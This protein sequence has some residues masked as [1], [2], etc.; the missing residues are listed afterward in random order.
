MNQLEPQPEYI[1]KYP[2][3]DPNKPKAKRINYALAGTLLASGME[4]DQIAP[5]VGA[6]N[7]ET[8]RAG[9]A[10]KGVT[11][12]MVRNLETK[13][14]TRISVTAKLATEA[15]SIIRQRLNSG[16]IQAADALLSKS[17]TRK[18]LS[19]KGQG[20]ASTLETLSRTWRN[21]NGSPDQVQVS[22]GLTMLNDSAPQPVV[23]CATPPAA[24]ID[25]EPLHVQVVDAASG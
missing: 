12:P 20:H 19:N 17:P 14:Q 24:A 25:I 18:S 4:W 22:F 10:R 5:S 9:C 2:P 8:L 23:S 6:K 16:L 15:E 11:K 21:L 7:G 13:G 1:S 3:R